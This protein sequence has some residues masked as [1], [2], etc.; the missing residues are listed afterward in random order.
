M[1]WPKLKNIIIL[2]LLL[3][4][5][6]MVSIVLIQE[7]D[8]ARYQ[9]QALDN[10]V[11]VLE[12]NG[13]QVDRE[14]IPDEMELDVLTVERDLETEKTLAEVLL[15]ACDVSELGGGRYAYESSL[16]SAEFRSNGNFS[17]TFLTGTRSVQKIGGEE[18][19][20]AALLK[21][22]ALTAEL[23][24]REEVENRVVLTY[25]Q[26]W[27][28]TPIHSCTITLEYENGS[29]QS[30]SGLRLMG[31]PQS[32]NDMSELISAPTALMRILNGINDLG[33]IC[34]EITTMEPGYLMTSA[35]ETIRLIPVWR[36]TTDTGVYS[37]NAL[38]GVLER[39]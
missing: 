20:A 28:N 19:H 21:E 27:Q 9:K 33:D 31:T 7:R 6:F 22:A 5:L 18:E 34:N 10:A 39:A 23:D 30:I 35:T 37:L 38:T 36:V 11:S 26:T 29:L 14:R 24:S 2:I 12:N 17:V 32:G 8:A 1:E 13:I 4:N 16:G 15:G 25:H 3:A